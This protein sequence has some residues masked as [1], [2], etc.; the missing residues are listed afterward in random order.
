MPEESIPVPTAAARVHYPALD[1]LRAL[2][3]TAVFLWHYTG[4]PW[5]WMGVDTFFALSGFLITGIL[6]DTRDAANRFRNFYIRRTL[7][8]FP[9]YYAVLL[10]LFAAGIWMHWSWNPGLPL[11]LVYLGNFNS[12]IFRHSP[13]I[14]RTQSF[15]VSNVRSGMLADNPVTLYLG[16]FW[17]LC[18]EEQFYLVWPLMIFMVRSRVRLMWICTAGVIAE[19]LL[20]LATLHWM[21]IG[22]V[23]DIIAWSTPF[24]VDALLLGALLALHL[25]GP[26]P[27]ALHRW[28]VLLALAGITVMCFWK[29]P[30]DPLLQTPAQFIWL[31]TAGLSLASV[32]SIAL[33]T[34]ALRP[35][36][37][38][39]RVLS[40]RPLREI[41][42]VS[43]GIY[44][45]HDIPHALYFNLFD[46]Y[47]IDDPR[48][49]AACAYA[50]T[51]ALAFLSFRFF[52][53][54]FL[55]LKERY[56]R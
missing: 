45:F 21:R 23:H 2:A 44:I 51:L 1:G 32:V 30:A 46:N 22:N 40:W 9:L 41:G 36:T 55:K 35:Q 50:C 3:V 10:L 37:L 24:R 8:I 13:E 17:S 38:L 28:A 15:L 31:L 33:V 49:V 4:L 20:R 12:L 43:Y 34:L 19:P 11:W 48:I 39:Y 56:T 5:G 29:I 52:E 25:R 6:Y 14:A 26:K 54:P 27:A 16:H 47:N 18:V 53:K 7:R 42:K